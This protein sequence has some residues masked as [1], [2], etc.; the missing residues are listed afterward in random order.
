MNKTATTQAE[1][2][3]EHRV[4][5]VIYFIQKEGPLTSAQLARRLRLPPARTNQWM[6]AQSW[7]FK[8]WV[9]MPNRR[10]LLLDEEP[11]EQSFD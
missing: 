8:L 5:A 2:E 11:V 4:E 7:R 10:W 1:V 9:R 6:R 3:R